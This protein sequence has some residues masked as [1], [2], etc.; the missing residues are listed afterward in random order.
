MSGE[1]F[2]GFPNCTAREDV[3]SEAL[4]LE[5]RALQRTPCTAAT[6]QVESCRMMLSLVAGLVLVL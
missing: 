5:C 1:G 6:L 4:Y 3:E 2:W